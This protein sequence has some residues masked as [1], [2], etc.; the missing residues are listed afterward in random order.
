MF[1]RDGEAAEISFQWVIGDTRELEKSF[2]DLSR[3]K[4]HYAITVASRLVAYAL[5]FAVAYALLPDADFH[6]ILWIAIAGSLSIWASLGLEIL[7]MRALDR[8]LAEDPR[9]VG[10]HSLWL[11]RAGI[12]WVTD[13]SEEYTSWLGVLEVVERG[14]S[15]WLK[16]GPAHGYYIPPRVFASEAELIEC[17]KLIQRLR[18]NPLPP[19]HL[20]GEREDLVKH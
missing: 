5:T 18:E 11:D 16:T 2:L 17:R 1:E 9:K 20:A 15:F 14:G 8:I 7:T 4:Y 12:S 10:W 6:T 19:R 13:T 3:P